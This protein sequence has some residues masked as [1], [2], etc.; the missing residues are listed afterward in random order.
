MAMY[1]TFQDTISYFK[2]IRLLL[3]L[4]IIIGLFPILNPC[5]LMVP[6]IIAFFALLLFYITV[7]FYENED[8]NFIFKLLVVALLLRLFICLLLYILAYWKRGHGFFLGA[9]DYG[10]SFNANLIMELWKETGQIPKEGA[11]RWMSK[12]GELNYT[13]F[14]SFIY[15]FIENNPL[16]PL[17]INSVVGAFTVFFIYSI[18][19]QMFNDKVARLSAIFSAFWPSLFL[20]STQNLKEPITVFLI[21]LC[22]WSVVRILNK[23]QFSHILICLIS[24]FFLY[25]IRSSIFYFLS[26]SLLI[27]I[28]S[29][30]LFKRRF[31][32]VLLLLIFCFFFGE[33][34]KI[35]L[36]DRLGFYSLLVRGQEPSVFSIL[37]TLR[38][39][40][41]ISAQSAFLIGFKIT[42]IFSFLAFLPLAL[43]YALFS[44]FPWQVY[45]LG[46]IPAVLEMLLWYLLIP[47]A[48]KGMQLA[49]QDISKRRQVLCIIVFVF[50]FLFILAISEGNTGTLFRHRAFIWPFCLMFSAAGIDA[51][52][53]QIRNA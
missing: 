28:L 26:I 47:F 46:Q 14:L 41:T 52:F 18:A 17:F 6:L 19:R 23:F 49:W 39:A 51:T 50:F 44:P 15:F 2:K 7:T 34:L 8:L 12:A 13:Y 43:I 27:S 37:N 40:K 1:K 32:K 16:I 9:D 5:G 35:A 25:K 4:G 3:I 24:L 53:K 21:S 48:F 33:K 11:L 31:L 45:N 29:I 10:F 42:N 22:L 36:L 20:W 38:Q 30:F